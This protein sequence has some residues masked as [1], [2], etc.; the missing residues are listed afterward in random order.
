MMATHGHI[1]RFVAHPG[2]RDALI[3]ALRPMFETV[4]SEPGT[5]LY[6]M[7]T[8]PADPDVVWFYERYA[9]EA[10]FEVHRTTQAH[11]DALIAIGPLLAS[12]PEIH[13][14][15]LVASKAT[16]ALPSK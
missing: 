10:A 6:L 4:R 11:D 7:H 1:V 12:A 9:D 16:E 5:L 15:E 3:T 13:F 14:L 8:S 2:Q